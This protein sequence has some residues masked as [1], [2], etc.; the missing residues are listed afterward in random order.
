VTHSVRN[1]LACPVPVRLDL[2][3]WTLQ[4]VLA[5]FSK[6]ELIVV[7]L[8]LQKE[9]PLHNLHDLSYVAEHHGVEV[10]LNDVASED[11]EQDVEV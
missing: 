11:Q 8:L 1:H 5:L 9:V 3:G 10:T 4:Q 2:T 7:C 6:E